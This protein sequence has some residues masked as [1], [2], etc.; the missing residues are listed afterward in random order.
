MEKTSFEKTNFEQTNFEKTNFEETNLEK[1]NSDYDSE[2][3]NFESRMAVETNFE[4]MDHK[5]KSPSGCKKRCSHSR[6][7]MRKR[8]GI[9]D[10]RRRRKLNE[11][12]QAI[13][14]HTDT[15]DGGVHTRPAGNCLTP[16]TWRS[17]S[18]VL[19]GLDI[20]MT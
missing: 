1:T 18:N 12:A 14:M 4:S 5:M 13:Q 15:L 11:K 6:S 20:V 17:P 7:T 10:G 9:K 8:Q 2:K 19:A 3:T 16:H